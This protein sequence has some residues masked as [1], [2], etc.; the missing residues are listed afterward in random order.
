MSSDD[1]DPLRR[2][3]Q[4]VLR[5]GKRRAVNGPVSATT[6]SAAAALTPAADGGIGCRRQAHQ[7]DAPDSDGR[8]AARGLG[9]EA[10]VDGGSVMLVAG[11]LPDG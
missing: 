11:A 7:H 5:S 10:P 3:Y 8:R 9:R 4:P 2:V 1:A 6:S